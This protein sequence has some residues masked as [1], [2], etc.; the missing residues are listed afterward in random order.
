[1]EVARRHS[2]AQQLLGLAV[3]QPLGLAEQQPLGVVGVQ[4]AAQR[5]VSSCGGASGDGGDSVRR[6]VVVSG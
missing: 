3:Q 6:P 1:M 2:C 5:T 4:A